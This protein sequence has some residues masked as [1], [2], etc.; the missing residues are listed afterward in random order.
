MV[1]HLTTERISA[2]LEEP[3][4]AGAEWEHLGAC[5][6]CEK[7]YEQMGRLR[8]ALSALPDEQPP[9][10]EWAAIEAALAANVAERGVG[11]KRAATV[12][13]RPA[14]AW[15]G[16][17]KPGGSL[18]RR[19]GGWLRKMAPL[20]AAAA[21]VL[22]LGGLVAGLQLTGGGESASSGLPEVVA[23]GDDRILLDGLD[24]IEQ[25]RAPLLQVGLGGAAADPGQELPTGLSVAG[26]IETARSLAR[27][28]GAIQALSDWLES[29]PD[30]PVASV[31][32]LEFI[33]MRHRLTEELDP[34]SR[35]RIW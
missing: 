21:V 14:E 34:S 27:L 12:F 7:E 19:R 26:S 29:H 33:E 15:P 2:L 20:Q 31:Y 16:Y 3:E 10:G 13:G 32:L 24:Q 5:P 30:D 35:T 4:A 18:A 28:D 23:S 9:P 1:K 25:F 8:M 17:A 22:F 6:E 11:G